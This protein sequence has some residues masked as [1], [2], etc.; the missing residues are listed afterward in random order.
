[1]ELWYA[2]LGEGS[3]PLVMC[4]G[5]GC[6]GF[7]WKYLTRELAPRHRV[8]RWH[9]RGHGRTGLPTDLA[10]LGIGWAADDLAAIMEAV[11]MEQAVVLGHSMGV[12]ELLEVH[13]RHPERCSALVPICGAYGNAL[14]TVHDDTT[15]KLAIPYVR[16][17][18]EAFPSLARAVSRALMPTELSLQ[19][20]LWFE[21]NRHLVRRED[22]QP[23]FMHLAKM[24]PLVFLRTLQSAADHTAWDHLG[25][26]DVPTLIV[27]AD[28]DKF[29]PLWLSQRMHRAIPGSEMLVVPSG[30]HTAPIELPELISLRIERFVKEHFLPK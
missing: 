19:Y 23:Y 28:H 27:A 5:L 26:I 13:R 24:D 21:V 30:T 3:P 20:A 14:D 6:D 8:L 11:G 17:A 18:A 7:A 12:Q 16:R 1:A 9:Y 15:I 29:T 22:F 25:R 2:Q 10:N 4:D